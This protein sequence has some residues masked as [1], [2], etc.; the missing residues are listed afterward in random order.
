MGAP[1]AVTTLRGGHASAEAP[2][3]A[4]AKSVDLLRGPPCEPAQPEQDASRPSS[5]PLKG[6][7]V[8]SF[9]SSSA[10]APVRHLRAL[11]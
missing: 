7:K 4:K 11:M 6:N 2:T 1:R 9:F 8:R 10:L 3:Q 5:A